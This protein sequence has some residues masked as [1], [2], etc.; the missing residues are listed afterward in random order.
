MIRSLHALRVF[1]S[2]AKHLNFAQAS[3]EL[4]L[5][6]SSVSRQITE[7]EKELNVALFTRSTR[8]VALTQQGQRLYE[9]AAPLV[10]SLDEV[11]DCLR[12]Q[13]EEVGGRVS[14]SA[15]WWFASYF[16]APALAGLRDHYPDLTVILDCDDRV[17]DPNEGLHDIYVRFGRLN[18]SRLLAKKF[19]AYEFWLIASPQYIEKYGEPKHPKDL[20]DHRLL[21][22]RF[23]SPHSSWIFDDGA[24]QQR[25]AMQSPYLLTNNTESI[26]HCALNHGGIGLLADHG[27]LNAVKRG[28]LI[29]LM[30]NYAITPNR[31]ENGMYLVYSKDKAKIKR[32]KAVID[33]LAEHLRS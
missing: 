30:P 33:Y 13:K 7:L 20:H 3:A 26:L 12:Q 9:E 4:H 32:V 21:A 31:F 28:E 18:D 22:Y 2:V 11:S 25:I 29:R 19:G 17:I 5:S 6:A 27:V 10:T 8:M 24:S 15:P 23:S 14:L 16:I 1:L